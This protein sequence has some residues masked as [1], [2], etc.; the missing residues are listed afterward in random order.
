MPSPQ[1]ANIQ[2]VETEIFHMR[3][4]S[5]YKIACEDYHILCFFFITGKIFCLT[6]LC[7]GL[8]HI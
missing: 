4:N 5:I 7:N 2:K 6:F 8:I 1:I 3:I